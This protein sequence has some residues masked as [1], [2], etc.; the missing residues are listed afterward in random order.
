MWS[1]FWVCFQNNWLS[2]FNLLEVAVSAANLAANCSIMWWYYKKIR[3]SWSNNNQAYI[4][5]SGTLRA[6]NLSEGKRL[7]RCFNTQRIIN[8]MLFMRICGKC[9]YVF[10]VNLEKDLSDM[11][12]LLFINSCNVW[13][14]L[15][16]SRLLISDVCFL[17]TRG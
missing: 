16:V 6:T 3:V 2:Y 10:Q 9:F 1:N 13:T 7:D 15:L 11:M 17:A 4:L 5:I 12:L 8:S 14:F